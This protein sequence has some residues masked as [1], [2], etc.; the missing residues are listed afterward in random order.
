[1]IERLLAFS[2]KNRLLIVLMA[3]GVLG[4]GAFALTRLPID[5]FPD[6]SPCSSRS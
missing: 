3:I 2:L 6:V 1:M 4:G 5:A